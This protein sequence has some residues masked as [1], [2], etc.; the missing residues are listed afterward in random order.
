MAKYST[1]GSSGAGDANACEL[2]GATSDS[3]RLATI[4]GAQLQVCGN[5]APHDDSAKRS[6]GSSTSGGG[7]DGPTDRKRRAAQRMA[8]AYDA[9]KGDPTHW[10]REGTAYEDDPLPYL[11][12][13]YGGVAEQGRQDAGLRTEE[14]AEELEIPEEQIVAIEQ[15][16]AARAGIPGSIIRALEER[17]D[18]R[19]VEEG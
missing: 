17:L 11:V 15:G 3:L 6:R 9:G 8:K 13:G 16:R 14:L 7:G 18:V 4:A 12:S 1:G 19:L 10:E 2:C 5:C